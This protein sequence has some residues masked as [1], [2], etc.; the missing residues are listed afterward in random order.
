M[1][2]ALEE[3]KY[4]VALVRV[5]PGHDEQLTWSRPICPLRP[6]SLV[7]IE[8]NFYFVGIEPIRGVDLTCIF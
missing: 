7:N 3:G 6:H 2:V 4:L 5:R 1:M 8:N